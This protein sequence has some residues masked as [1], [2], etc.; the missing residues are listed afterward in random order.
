MRLQAIHTRSPIIRKQHYNQHSKQPLPEVAEPE[1]EMVSEPAIQWNN[2]TKD[3][4]RKEIRETQRKMQQAAKEMDFLAAAKY[5]DQIR[6]MQQALE[7]A[8]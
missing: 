6:D 4:L 5:R 8:R 3:Q 1:A 7:D 2:K